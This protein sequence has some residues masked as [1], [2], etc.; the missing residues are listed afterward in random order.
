[1]RRSRRIAPLAIILAAAACATA[2]EK[3][4]APPPGPEIVDAAVVEASPVDS[5]SVGDGGL[6]TDDAC[7]K[8]G[9]CK[10]ILPDDE[11]FLKDVWPL[12]G[13]AF[14]L[15]QSF[16]LGVKVL[17]WDDDVEAWS[18]IDDGTQHQLGQTEEIATKIWAPNDNEVYYA[19]APRY[20]YHGTRQ[21]T[22]PPTW[23]WT[24][25]LLDDVTGNRPEWGY[26]LDR[27]LGVWGG[28][29]V[30][31]W[32]GNAAFRLNGDPD[33]PEWS[34][35]YTLDDGGEDTM[36]LFGVNGTSRDDLWFV[37]AREREW[38]QC[39]VVVHKTAA[40]YRTVADGTVADPDGNPIPCEVGPGLLEIGEY[41][42]LSSAQSP[43]VGE[44]FAIKG[45]TSITRIAR[46]NDGS[47]SVRS[48]RPPSAIASS[49][50][51]SLWAPSSAETWIVGLG[52]VLRGSNLGADGGTYEISSIALNGAPLRRAFYQVRG[53]SNSN[54]WAVGE[55][56]ALHKKSSK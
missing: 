22:S 52:T 1:M 8:D 2:G 42:P 25:S 24:R 21:S 26:D 31:A 18:Y 19:V 53:T 51:Q 15:G 7:S 33:A 40:G 34:L 35:E 50:W 3:Q 27:A 43:S 56:Y 44:I 41:G 38:E 13:R 4:D 20:I 45:G 28:G 23:T 30:Y 14:A 32:Y 12:K 46:G 16:N 49:S 47:Y 37:G 6:T 17:E 5:S 36:F 11:L 39:D 9:W 54:L 29:D 55:G 48:S 10:T